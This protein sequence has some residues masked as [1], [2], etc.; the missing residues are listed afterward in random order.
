[1]VFQAWPASPVGVQLDSGMG[2]DKQPRKALTKLTARRPED[3]SKQ[4]LAALFLCHTQV[5]RSTGKSLF[6]L[7]YGTQPN[8]I[9]AL[10]GPELE[11]PNKVPPLFSTQVLLANSDQEE[12]EESC[13]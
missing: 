8:I 2:Y 4:L 5:N 7:V 12:K 6:E 10:K 11:I 13:L 1:M 3:W 9:Q